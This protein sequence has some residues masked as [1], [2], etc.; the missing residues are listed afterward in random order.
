MNAIFCFLVLTFPLVAWAG[1]FSERFAEAKT[2]GDAAAMRGFLEK[3]AET[4]ADNPDYYALAGNH[5]WQLSRTPVISAKP[6]EEGDLSIR[7]QETGKE[8]GSIG[9]AAG[10][11]PELRAKAL[12]L[13]SEG[14]RRFPNRADLV[15]GLASVQKALG[16][17]AE[18]VATLIAMLE[19]TN[20]GEL[21]WTA[22]GELPS[23]VENFIPEAIQGYTAGLYQDESEESDALCTKLCDS[24]I[25]V[26]PAHPYAYNI[27][28]A[29]AS[30]QGK[31][32]ES[33]E[34]LGIAAAKAPDDPLIL[35]NHADALLKA[36]KKLD[37][38]RAYGKVLLLEGADDSLKEEARKLMDGIE[39]K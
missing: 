37:A 25:Q 35:L 2:K 27:K 1:D 23:K 12:G 34:L 14:V 7:D 17:D 19:K 39:T 13:L 21:K 10:A 6:S 28:A 26:Y 22:N 36:G 9:V 29:L 24:V 33:L 5:W 11:D 20:P 15:L 8:V 31:H 38:K 3:A 32:A 4:E 18:A 16:K 30:A